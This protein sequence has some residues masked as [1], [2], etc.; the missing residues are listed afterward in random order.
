MA[1]K[2]YSWPMSS[3]SRVHWALEELGIPYEYVQL[4][5]TKNEHKQ[6]EYLAINPNGKVPALVDDGVAY[7]ESLA[8][9]LHLG[10]RYGVERNVWP[11]AGQAHADALSWCIWGVAELQYN[12]REYAYHGLQTRLSYKPEDQSKGAAEFNHGVLTKH[13]A[14]LD[15]RLA[16]R[17]YV[18]G[19]FTLADC[20]VGSTLRFGQMVGIAP[21]GKHVTAYVERLNKR[22]AVAKIR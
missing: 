20:T 18:C 12:L 16:D 6:P 15:K 2:F 22:P 7:F 9:I 4:D 19:N 5:R 11:S 13:F 17:E 10:E 21:E 3:G 14:M 1:I 8:I